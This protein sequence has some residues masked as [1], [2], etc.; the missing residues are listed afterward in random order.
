MQ[1]KILPQVI[2]LSEY[3]KK[4]NRE[5]AAER[6]DSDAVRQ[7]TS[8]TDLLETLFRF[9]GEKRRYVVAFVRMKLDRPGRMEFIKEL[10]ACRDMHD[11]VRC[12]KQFAGRL[13]VN[14]FAVLMNSLPAMLSGKIEALTYHGEAMPENRLMKF[15][16]TLGFTEADATGCMLWHLFSSPANT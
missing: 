3:A 1:T 8:R 9:L 4:E 6:R 7:R 11:E 13:K 15:A 16:S 14:D 12:V 5:G 2:T 10:A